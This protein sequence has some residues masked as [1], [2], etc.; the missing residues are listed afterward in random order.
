MTRLIAPIAV[1]VALIAG[2]AVFEGIKMERWAKHETS[3]EQKV[4]AERMKSIPFAFGDW[5]SSDEPISQRDLEGARAAGH[6]SRRFHNR[7]DSSKEVNILII[8][9]APSDICAHTP[10]KCYANSGFDALGENDHYIINVGKTPAEFYTNRFRR[11]ESGEAIQNLRIFWSF[12]VDGSWLAPTSP[13]YQ[14]QLAGYSALCKIYAITEL[15]ANSEGR[16]D[17]SA[18]VGFLEKFLPVVNEHLFPSDKNA[19]S[20]NGEKPASTDAPSS[21]TDGA[22]ATGSAPRAPA[23]AN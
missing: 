17:E 22:A 2:S 6:Y 15:P 16:P 21:T 10:E 7:L 19:T 20:P 18:A 5:E 12:S 4:F 9:G 11:G 23:D 3:A 14:F 8:V 13:K 1:V